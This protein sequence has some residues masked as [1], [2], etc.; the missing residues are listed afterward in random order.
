MLRHGCAPVR[1]LRARQFNSASGRA[2]SGARG[3]VEWVKGTGLGP[4]L[5]PLDE[6]E[7]KG[8]LT[9]YEEK[10]QRAY[11][12]LGDGTVPLRF[13]RLFLVGVR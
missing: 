13:P 1:L 12:S 2:L 11:P 6:T 5:D 10:L 4:Y 3:I 7:R 9:A 8:F